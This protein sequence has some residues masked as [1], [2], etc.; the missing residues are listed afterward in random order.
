MWDTPI[1]NMIEVQ[2]WAK[3]VIM[4]G[5]PNK[6]IR[7]KVLIIMNILGSSEFSENELCTR[8]MIF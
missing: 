5:F 3:I 4:N 1:I 6:Y 2:E 8:E 7:E